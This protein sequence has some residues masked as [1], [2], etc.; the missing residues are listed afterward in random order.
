MSDLPHDLVRHI[1]L[2]ADLSIDARLALGVPPRRLRVSPP[3]GLLNMLRIRSRA[4]VEGDVLGANANVHLRRGR[5]PYAPGGAPEPVDES[6]G[7][8]IY[9]HLGTMVYQMEVVRTFPGREE[10]FRVR[11]ACFD[12]ATGERRDDAAI[13]DG[14]ED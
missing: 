3:A 2:R 9:D 10:S 8:D 6:M 5:E 7:L 13:D 12:L 11:V 1:L 14:D 4:R